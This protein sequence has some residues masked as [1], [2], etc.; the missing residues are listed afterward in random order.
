MGS[1]LLIRRKCALPY[2]VNIYRAAPKRTVFEDHLVCCSDER[3]L[4]VCA[5]Q[6]E[7]QFRNGLMKLENDRLQ[8]MIAKA[9]EHGRVDSH[10]TPRVIYNWCDCSCHLV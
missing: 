7:E 1:K 2:S 3:K 8:D 5:M 4:I 9:A 10:L 6:G